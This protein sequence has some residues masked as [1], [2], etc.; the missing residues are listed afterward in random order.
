MEDLRTFAPKSSYGEVFFIS[1][2]ELVN[3]VLTLKMKKKKKKKKKKRN[4]SLAFVNTTELQ[5]RVE[6]KIGDYFEEDGFQVRNH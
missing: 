6:L 2:Q 4:T 1:P 3:K 5:I